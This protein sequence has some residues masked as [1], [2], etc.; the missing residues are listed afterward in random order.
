MKKIGILWNKKWQKSPNTARAILSDLCL[1]FLWTKSWWVRRV[2]KNMKFL[3][4]FNTCTIYSDT[5][6]LPQR[7]GGRGRS[8]VHP[9][10]LEGSECLMKTI[11][12]D[13]QF[14]TRFLGGSI[15]TEESIC[16]FLKFLYMQ[17]ENVREEIILLLNRALAPSSRLVSCFSSLRWFTFKPRGICLPA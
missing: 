6:R 1:Y 5:R 14:Q 7:W 3:A 12:P 11:W 8:W 17:R 10:P 13:S 4:E 15:Y 9:C 2:I 16:K